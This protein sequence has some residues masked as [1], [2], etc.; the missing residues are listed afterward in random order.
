MSRALRDR[1]ALYSVGPQRLD[2]LALTQDLL[3]V[4]RVIYNGS[5][6]CPI[7]VY[8]SRDDVDALYTLLKEE[9]EKSEDIAK[10]ALTI[11]RVLLN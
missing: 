3:G 7:Y 4:D 10:D 6:T 5:T 1:L 9:M 11:A 8:A 2:V